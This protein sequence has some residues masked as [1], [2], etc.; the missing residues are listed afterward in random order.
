MIYLGTKDNPV[1]ITSLTKDSTLV[2]V[3]LEKV[4]VR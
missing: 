3:I 1:S 2:L 4:N